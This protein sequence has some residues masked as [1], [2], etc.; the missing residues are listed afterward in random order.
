VAS[1]LDHPPPSKVANVNRTPLSHLSDEVLRREIKSSTVDEKNAT[2]KLILRIAEYCHRK[3]YLQ[4]GFPSM[5]AYCIGELE[6][7]PDEAAKRIQVARA[8]LRCPGVFEALAERRIHLTGMRILA[9]H[10]TPEN[11]EE[12]LSPP[13]ASRGRTCPPRSRPSR[14]TSPRLRPTNVPRGTLCHPK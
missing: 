1:A 2:A 3:L 14:R 12:L 5:R 4:D 6:L 13:S 10:L 9:P 11:A 8:G 7:S